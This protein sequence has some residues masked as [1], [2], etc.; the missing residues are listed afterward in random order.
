MTRR[1]TEF[2][3][4]IRVE[5]FERAGGC[6]E[7]C[8]VSIRPGNGPEYDHRVPCALGGEATLENCAVLC[9][10][11]HGTKT[12]KQDVPRIAKAKRVHRGQINAQTR[13]RYVMPG[14]RASGLK[15]RL[16]GTV[17]RRTD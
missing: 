5:A 3:A 16:D 1:R 14:S 7:E 4:K 12:A 8:G 11:C 9:R 10:S 6:C 2:S 17:V 13:P 15:K